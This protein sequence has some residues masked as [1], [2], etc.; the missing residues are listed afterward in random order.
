MCDWRKRKKIKAVEYKG[1]KCQ[2]CGYKKSYNSLDF[3][4][5]DPSQKDFSISQVNRSWEITK[6]E[7]DKCILVCSNCHGEIHEEIHIKGTSSIV[8]RIIEKHKNFKSD[9]WVMYIDKYY[10]NIFGQLKNNITGRLLK[11][12]I[13][14]NGYL[15][16]GI[17]INGKYIDVFPHVAVAETFIKE[18]PRKT[19]YVTHKDNDKKN[20]HVSNLE[21]T[22]MSKIKN[23]SFEK[24]SV[25]I[26]M[27]EVYKYSN[28]GVFL[29]KYDS[30]KEAATDIN[31]IDSCIHR[32]CKGERKRHMGFLW[33]YGNKTYRNL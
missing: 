12:K 14:N 20:N 9:E 23:I 31:G 17:S 26:N 22:N 25:K 21:Y 6:K 19:K 27:R 30:V 5:I 32:C 13:N 24:K 3:H 15:Y 10:I 2:D 29:K 16:Y 33:K 11:H 4:H 1:G 28:D 18:K 7:L 8:N